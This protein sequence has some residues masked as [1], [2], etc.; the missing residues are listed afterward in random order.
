[1]VWKEQRQ[2]ECNIQGILRIVSYHHVDR[3]LNSSTDGKTA[4]VP[5]SDHYSSIHLFNKVVTFLLIK[6][7]G[8]Q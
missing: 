2:S 1:M 3:E 4:A 6:S 5:F 8:N 7:N